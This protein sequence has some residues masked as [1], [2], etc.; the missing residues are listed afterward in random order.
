MEKKKKSIISASLTVETS[1]VLPVFLIFFAV[2]LYFIQIFILQEKLQQVITDVGLSYAKTA[3]FY[4][5]FLNIDEAKNF[6]E[7][8][9]DEELREELRI[10]LD[11]A[12]YAGMIKYAV[13]SRL[14]EISFNSSCIA[15]GLEGINFDCS[16][17]MQG[18]DDIDIVASYKVRIPIRFFG[19]PEID[20]IQRVRLRAWSGLKLPPLYSVVEDDDKSKDKTVYVTESGSVYHLDINCSHIKLSVKAINQIPTWQ[21]NNNGGKYYPCESC[22]KG[23]HPE[24]GIYFITAYG[25]RYHIK[26]DCS[27]IKRTIRQV[28]LSEVEHLHP[29]KRCKGG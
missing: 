3:Y 18:S 13:K 8:F 19:L 12:G 28:P 25:D 21:R 2:F 5:D 14:N 10:F 4:S 9:L 16:K 27:R 23:E 17:V 29:C 15:G 26:E 7:S 22:I 24:T 11:A 20:M 1:L 6:D